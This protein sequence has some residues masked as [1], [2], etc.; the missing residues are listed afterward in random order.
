MFEFAVIALLSLA[1]IKVVDLLMDFLPMEPPIL[2]SLLTFI[3][4]IGSVWILDYSVFAGWGITLRNGT[5]AVWA[6]GFIVAGMTSGWRAIFRLFTHDTATADETL[7]EH[8]RPLRK[9]A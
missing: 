7:G 4:A 2:R 6:T 5:L 3:V 1:T 8:H 9:V